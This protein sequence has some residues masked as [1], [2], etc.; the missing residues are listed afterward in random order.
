M[1]LSGRTSPWT[2][3]APPNDDDYQLDFIALALHG[4]RFGF[5]KAIAMIGAVVASLL[6]EQSDEDYAKECCEAQSDLSDDSRKAP[7]CKVSKEEAM[8]AAT[9]EAIALTRRRSWS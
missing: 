5:G 1:W 7:V 9:E 8:T 2:P 4:E 6:Q 3:T